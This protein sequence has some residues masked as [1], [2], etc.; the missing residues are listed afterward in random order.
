MKELHYT[1]SITPLPI[2]QVV[3]KLDNRYIVQ[4]RGEQTESET[5]VKVWKQLI[6]VLEA[7]LSYENII[8]AI[9]D[10]KYSNDDVTAITLNYL[11]AV[12]N[13]VGEDKKEEYINEYKTL[14]AW[15]QKAKGIAKEVLEF[16][17]KQNMI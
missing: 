3:D 9:V 6:V 4:N 1:T 7:P 8:A 16:A 17:Q 5:G 15:R 10:A 14:Q 13:E 2:L 12:H 11:L